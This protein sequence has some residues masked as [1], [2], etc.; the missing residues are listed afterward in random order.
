MPKLDSSPVLST[1]ELK[2]SVTEL[3]AKP[4]DEIK[5]GG[6]SVDPG[7]DPRDSEEWVFILEFTDRRSKVW[8]G[9]FTNKILTLGE[10][11]LVR[12]R[13]SCGKRP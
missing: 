2:N 6:A 4:L 8:H 9:Q 5:S 12:R 1:E 7:D 11:Q 10:Q 13:S 3:I